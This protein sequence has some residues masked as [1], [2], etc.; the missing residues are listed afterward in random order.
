LRVRAWVGQHGPVIPRE[1]LSVATALFR[2]IESADIDAVAALY[3]DD[4]EVWH[5]T[6]GVVQNKQE[7]LRVLGWVVRNLADLRYE[8]VRRDALPDGFVQQ[9]VLHATAPSGRSVAIPA[10]L[11]VTIRDG[12]ISRLDEYLD[13]AQIVAL[14]QPAVTG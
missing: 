6:D 13:S 4:V 9:H 11:V 5:N 12:L 10:C 3:H 7:N 1:P 14:T 2:A 8:V